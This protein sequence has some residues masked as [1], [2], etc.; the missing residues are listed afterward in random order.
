MKLNMGS[1]DR[2]FRLIAAAI[3]V[4]L[5]MSD[6]VTGTWGIVL[7][8]LGAVFVVTSV[9]GVCPLYSIFRLR[10]TPKKIK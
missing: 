4:W 8:V 6:T 2:V 9:V 1:F 7:L 3:F 5:Y 10:T